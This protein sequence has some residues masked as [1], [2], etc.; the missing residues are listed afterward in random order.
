MYVK[1]V[2]MVDD[3]HV[4]VNSF[5]LDE[6]GDSIACCHLPTADSPSPERLVSGQLRSPIVKK[7]Y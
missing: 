5:R 1:V 3:P 6:V 2:L 7:Y 4:S